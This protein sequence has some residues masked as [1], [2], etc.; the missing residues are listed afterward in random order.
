MNEQGMERMVYDTILSSET[1]KTQA[2]MWNMLLAP[3]MS[4]V[5]HINDVALPW[6]LHMNTSFYVR[7]LVMS[8]IKVANLE[9]FATSFRNKH[10]M[11]TC[12]ALNMP[13]AVDQIMRVVYE[14]FVF[15]TK[16][17]I[18]V[19]RLFLAPTMAQLLLQLTALVKGHVHCQWIFWNLAKV[20]E[21]FS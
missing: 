18:V 13:P 7:F 6:G 4:D 8:M 19:E 3:P 21:D 16:D 15:T 17:K 5:G 20:F 10:L 9:Y 12:A 14:V 2:N 11:Q 1:N